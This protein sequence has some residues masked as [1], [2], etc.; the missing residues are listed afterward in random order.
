VGNDYIDAARLFHEVT[1]H[2]YTSVRSSP[3]RLDW[4][5]KPSPYKIYPEAAAIALPRDLKLSGMPALEAIAKEVP[6]DARAPMGVPELTR[7]LFCADGLTRRARVDETEYHF[8]AAPSA[9]ALYPIEIYVAAADVEGLEAG[10]Y[11]FSPADLKLRGLR[12]GDWRQLIARSAANRSSLEYARAIVITS[13]IFWR[14]T[15]KYRARG[16]RYCFWDGGTMLANLLAAAVADGI[17]AKVITAFSDPDLEGLLGIDGDSEGMVAIVALGASA[18][19]PDSSPEVTPLPFESIPISPSQVDYDELRKIH[20]E[21]RLVSPE[22]VAAVSMSQVNDVRRP[23]LA[24]SS[25]G[26]GET[27]LRRGSTRVFS[28]DSIPAGDLHAIMAASSAPLRADFPRFIDTY[29]IVN[30]VEGME[31][32][33]YRYDRNTGA[34]DLIKGG[35]FR[36]EAGYLCLEQPLGM[37]CSALVVYMADL[38]GALK[39]SGNRAYRNLHLEAG[40]AGGRAYLAAYALGHGATGL[41]FYDDDTT[42]FFGFQKDKELP[43]FM[44]AIGVAQ[45]RRKD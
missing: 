36:G 31:P 39:T 41:T 22:E 37:D 1:K 23:A 33:A 14:S 21:S 44:T 9:G 12:R 13:S 19:A 10:L 43:I 34:F 30:A 42:G 38:D 18:G 3:H 8:R 29:L 6:A 28:H 11:H 4:D 24:L 45:A 25:R 7:I 27:I 17:P 26:L 20:R 15:W 5:I 32:G 35:S 2:S 40:I 16:Y